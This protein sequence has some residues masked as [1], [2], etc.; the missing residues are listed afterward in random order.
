[1]HLTLKWTYNLQRL[2]A[3]KEF[4]TSFLSLILHTVNLLIRKKILSLTLSKI[5]A[6]S[7]SSTLLRFSIMGRSECPT[8]EGY[9]GVGLPASRKVWTFPLCWISPHQN[10]ESLWPL[11]TDHILALAAFRKILSKYFCKK[12][13]P[14][15]NLLLQLSKVSFLPPSSSSFH[16]ITLCKIDLWLYLLLLYHFL[17]L[18]IDFD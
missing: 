5:I 10:T 3:I 15:E 13:P 17:T 7:R 14:P 9:L 11:I 1:M 8:K 6:V 18:G 2:N 4:S 16:L 12:N